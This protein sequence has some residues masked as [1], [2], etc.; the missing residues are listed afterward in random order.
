MQYDEEIDTECWKSN[1]RFL[2]TRKMIN[3]LLYIERFS[4]WMKL[5]LLFAFESSF[6]NDLTKTQST[7]HI[8]TFISDNKISLH[9]PQFC[10]IIRAEENSEKHVNYLTT[11][12]SMNNDINEG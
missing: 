3:Q 1:R 7:R 6:V 5:G 2:I 8:C 10:R 12:M 11:F 9:M 4:Q